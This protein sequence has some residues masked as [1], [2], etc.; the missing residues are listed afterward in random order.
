M[1]Q[2]PHLV[3]PYVHCTRGIEREPCAIAQDD[4]LLLT[5]CGAIVRRPMRGVPRDQPGRRRTHGRS[6]QL[7]QHTSSGE[8]ATPL[9]YLS[10][11][12]RW[13]IVHALQKMLGALP[14]AFVVCML[15][16]PLL[17]GL[18]I[19]GCRL[20]RMQLQQPGSRFIQHVGIECAVFN[21]CVARHD[22]ATDKQARNARSMCRFTV[23]NDTDKRSAISAYFKPSNCDN[24]NTR[25]VIAGKVSSI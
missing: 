8:L 25:R 13:N 18:M 5:R 20:T 6:Q 2:A 17:Q 1:Q 10:A 15:N 19:S 23:I 7:P 11:H 21:S 14:R 16:A 4:L 3:K 24:K 22:Y 9:Q 12:R